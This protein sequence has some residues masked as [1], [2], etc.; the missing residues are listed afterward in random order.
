M[1]DAVITKVT[2]RAAFCSS[3]YI[4]KINLLTGVCIS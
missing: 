2:L 4:L 1:K 3:V